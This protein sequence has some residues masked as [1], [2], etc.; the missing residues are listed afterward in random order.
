MLQKQ[1]SVHI[2][3]LDYSEWKERYKLTDEK[4]DKWEDYED[5]EEEE[6]DPGRVDPKTREKQWNEYKEN[7]ERKRRE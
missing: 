4:K 7:I 5:L 3:T 1:D 2:G 6:F